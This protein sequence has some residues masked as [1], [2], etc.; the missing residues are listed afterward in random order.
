MASVVFSAALS[1]AGSP[2]PAPA[3]V[4]RRAASLGASWACV[5]PSGRSFSG[6]VV[7][8]L[9]GSESA[10]SS[11]ASFAAGRL[12]VPFCA[13]RAAGAFWSVSVPCL[14][15]SLPACPSGC[16]P[17]GWF[18]LSGGSG[19]SGLPAPVVAALG[20]ASAVGFSGSRSAAPPAPVVAAV[21]AA[22]PAGCPVSVGCARG[23]DAAFRAAFPAARVFSVRSFGSGRGAFAARSV[24]CVQSVAV[25]GGLWVSF[26][27]GSCPP[28]LVP[29][30][31]SGRC[32]C[33]SGS[34][35]WA[36][37]AFAVGLGVACFVWLPPAFSVP[38]GWGFS[39]VGGGWW[40]RSGS[41]S[42][43]L[44]LL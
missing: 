41:G 2:A 38:S 17:L 27:F 18:C 39:S 14:V 8:C 35:S 24:A 1:P 19:G 16:L 13:V 44:S 3:A 11:F 9:F 7:A 23:V 10:A 31:S 32:F 40:L 25:P 4:V 6:W 43:Q 12:S 36:S 30:A 29:S 28:G 33:G 22:V 20:S 21:A 34:G 42:A 5:R 37:L 26:P 15:V